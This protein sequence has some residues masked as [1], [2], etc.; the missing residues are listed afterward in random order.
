MKRSLKQSKMFN[1]KRLQTTPAKPVL[2]PSPEAA[3]S[4]TLP[5][6]LRT[7]DPVRRTDCGPIWA[8][9]GAV[10]VDQKRYPTLWRAVQAAGK[11]IAAVRAKWGTVEEAARHG[12]WERAE[13]LRKE[14]LGV[15]PVSDRPVVVP[16]DLP[17]NTADL[18]EALKKAPDKKAAGKIRAQ[19]RAAGI[20][21]GLRA[22]RTVV[23]MVLLCLRV[24]LWL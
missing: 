17:A 8:P 6:G 22:L 3:R 24:M 21:G 10:L 11:V 15:A 2:T 18:V 7:P 12:H 14:V 4:L 19:L 9:D 13:A 16:A 1:A 23:P 20:R 5:G